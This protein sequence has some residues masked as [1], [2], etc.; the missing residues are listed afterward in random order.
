MDWANVYRNW[1]S[2]LQ[3]YYCKCGGFDS[4]YIETD[5]K[6]K[7]CHFIRDEILHMRSVCE[8]MRT[9]CDGMFRPCEG[10]RKACGRMFGLCEGVRMVCKRMRSVCDMLRRACEGMR[11]LCEGTGRGCEGVFRACG[12]MRVVLVFC[13][14]HCGWKGELKEW[15]RIGW[16]RKWWD[17]YFCFRMFDKS[18]IVCHLLFNA[19][20]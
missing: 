1:Q 2:I 20:E 11:R 13:I 3:S 10:M 19:K 14:L 12:G 8:V 9:L 18:W 5:L 15:L 7:V 4:K 16:G 6:I 17:S